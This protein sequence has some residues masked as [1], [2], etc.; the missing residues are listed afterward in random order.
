M[1]ERSADETPKKPILSRDDSRE[2]IFGTKPSADGDASG[3]VDG[4]EGSAKAKRTRI[5]PTETRNKAVS[6]AL[7]NNPRLT[8]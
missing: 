4:L 1:V 7:G 2:D 5:T 3:A 8:C 6:V